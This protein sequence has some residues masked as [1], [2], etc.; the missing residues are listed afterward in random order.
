MTHPLSTCK[1]VRT[2]LTLEELPFAPLS[3]SPLSLEDQGNA[4]FSH[5]HEDEFPRMN[6]GG[7]FREDTPSRQFVN[8]GELPILVSPPL[9]V[10]GLPYRYKLTTKYIVHHND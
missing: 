10:L 2:A 4:E 5:D 6:F 8:K 3:P 7:N 9:P 1:L